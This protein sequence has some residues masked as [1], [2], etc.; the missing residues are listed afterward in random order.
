VLVNGTLKS[1]GTWT[2]GIPTNIIVNSSVNGTF[3]YTLVA[4]D[5]AG[6]SVQDSVILTVTA[7]GMDPG[8]I[9]T[10]VIVSIAAGI[11]ALLGI[12]F[13]LKRRG[14]TKPRKKE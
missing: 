10:I 7:S 13:M 5:G 11:V 4:S 6:A 14:K 2:S 9:A 3:E 12:A 8:I 1:T